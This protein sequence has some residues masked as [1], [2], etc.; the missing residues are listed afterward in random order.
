MI[1]VTTPSP[2]LSMLQF[3]PLALNKTMLLVNDGRM[4]RGKHVLKASRWQ[5]PKSYNKTESHLGTCQ[6]SISFKWFCKK[7]S[8]MDVWQCPQYVFNNSTKILK[9]KLLRFNFLF[10]R[11]LSVFKTQTYG[12]ASKF[13]KIFGELGPNVVEYT[14]KNV[15][16]SNGFTD[17]TKLWV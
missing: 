16:I 15:S 4:T 7:I 6:T 11:I 14:M 8:I 3:V 13:S 10:R 5:A 12:T 17:W 1:W 9:R 2:L